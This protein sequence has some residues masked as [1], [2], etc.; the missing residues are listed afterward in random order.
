MKIRTMLRRCRCELPK[1][2]AISG[3]AETGSANRLPLLRGSGEGRVAPI[4]WLEAGVA[5]QS[6]VIALAET[7]G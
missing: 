5:G 4:V 7:L 6:C 2:R 1:G 3:E